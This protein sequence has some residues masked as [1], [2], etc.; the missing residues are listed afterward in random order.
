MRITQLLL[1]L[2]EG[3]VGGRHLAVPDPH[4]RGGLNG[5]EGLRDNEVTA[6]PE[7]FVVG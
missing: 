3:T 4:G 5:L 2:G 7:H 6:L 1:P